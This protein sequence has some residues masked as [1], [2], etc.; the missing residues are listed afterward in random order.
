[1][2]R[3]FIN[4]CAQA[5]SSLLGLSKKPTGL[6]YDS[7]PGLIGLWGYVVRAQH[8]ARAHGLG[9]VPALDSMFF[10]IVTLPSNTKVDEGLKQVSV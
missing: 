5:Y 6:W 4:L 2:S 3:I 9:P 10:I 1:M 8:Q 7:G